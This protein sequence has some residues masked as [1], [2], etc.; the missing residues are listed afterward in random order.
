[1]K[2][3][4]AFVFVLSLIVS[5][6]SGCRIDD[7]AFYSG[8]GAGIVSDDASGLTS[9][10][11]ETESAF[12]A[13]MAAGG[14]AHTVA[15]REDG[16]VWG[17]GTDFYGCI[18]SSYPV[19]IEGLSDIVYIDAGNFA[20]AAIKSD[21]TLWMWGVSWT[22]T[23]PVSSYSLS[24]NEPLMTDVIDVSVGDYFTV[25]LKSDGTVWIWGVNGV[26][27]V[28]EQKVPK[29]VEGL[30]KIKKIA[31]S[32][33][34]AA[35]LD[36]E[37][38]VWFL[39]EQYIM[40]R[41]PKKVEGLSDITKIAGGGHHFIALKSDGTVCSFSESDN[42][43]Y[44]N[45]QVGGLSDIIDIAAG[46]F[47]SVAVK[48]DGTVWS[49]GFFEHGL[50]DGVNYNSKTPVKV[51][52]PANATGVASGNWHVI[53]TT[54]DG[55]WAWGSN[56]TGQLGYGLKPTDPYNTSSNRSTPVKVSINSIIDD[57]SASNESSYP[58]ESQQNE[59]SRYETSSPIKGYV[60]TNLV[61]IYNRIDMEETVIIKYT[62]DSNPSFLQ[63]DKAP[64]FHILKLVD[65]YEWEPYNSL[66]N[67]YEV[68][69]FVAAIVCEDTLIT[70]L[71]FARD[72]Q[73]KG[74]VYSESDEQI[75]YLPEIVFNEI[76]ETLES[77]EKYYERYWSNSSI[78]S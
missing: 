38:N 72:A 69:A 27:N 56:Y 23:G 46:A 73:G 4:V 20:S 8:V 13:K 45:Y 42:P 5:L 75:T 51:V 11:D 77:P 48:K 29:K 22:T 68:G 53:I 74:F 49:W 61:E 76:W 63:I 65:M 15:L 2:K 19:Q 32:W 36:E 70:N 1:M 47:H 33:Y 41:I 71:L 44:I 55:L 34:H 18:N 62:N 9:S 6:L 43:G 52:L 28:E 40:P 50:G 54:P 10:E 3:V 31:T 58:I 24:L 17:W 16:T 59:T 78:Y 25:A 30:P 35:F 7:A 60:N 57:N 64:L 26:D 37:G 14:Y 67:A 21:G 66:I 39:E 12:K